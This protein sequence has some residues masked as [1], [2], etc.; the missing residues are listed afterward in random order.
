MPVKKY[1]LVCSVCETYS[2]FEENPEDSNSWEGLI[3]CG[4]LISSRCHFGHHAGVHTEEEFELGRGGR[5]SAYTEWTEELKDLYEN[6]PRALV[7][8]EVFCKKCRTIHA[9]P[10]GMKLLN[11]Y[12]L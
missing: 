3:R 6:P 10:E 2:S 4:A 11:N 5:Y 9:V 8:G 12:Y 7:P 1:Y